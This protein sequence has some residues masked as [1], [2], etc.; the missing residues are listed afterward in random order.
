MRA[1]ENWTLRIDSGEYSPW[2]GDSYANIASF[3]LSFQRSQNG[4]RY[5]PAAGPN[6][7]YYTAHGVARDRAGQRRVDL[8]R[9]R[10]DLRGPVQDARPPGAGGVDAT[11]AAIDAA[12]ARAIS[13]FT[14][15]DPS[16]AVP[17]LAEGLRLTRDAIGEIRERARCRCTSCASRNANSRKRLAPR[18]AWS[19]P[20]LADRRPQAGPDGGGR[21]GGRGGV[22]TM[23]AP[24]PGQT[25]GVQRAARQS[26]RY[27]ESSCADV[28]MAAVVAR[29]AA[30]RRHRAAV[31]ADQQQSG[32]VF[33]TV[34]VADD[35]PI[36]TKPY[37]SRAAFTENRY[38]L[39]DPSSFGRPFNPPP[40]VAVANYALNGVDVEMTE[41][42][43]RREPNLPYGYVVREVRTVPRSP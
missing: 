19:C 12:V 1:D 27:A 2:L 39:S 9:H 37:F 32:I 3:G 4:G 22:A 42:V 28:L 21:G 35:A 34:T 40:L 10:H 11:L 24:V 41:V 38:T 36:S 43:R 13:A 30:D 25:F 26:R 14:F 18:S 33:F 8:R 5:V 20:R 31:I 7:S 23:T 17:A 6:Y 16:S 15:T 29:F